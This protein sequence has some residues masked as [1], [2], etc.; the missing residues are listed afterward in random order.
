[1]TE[2]NRTE[3]NE[4]PVQLRCTNC[5]STKRTNSSVHFMQY[6]IRRSP[7]KL[8]RVHRGLNEILADATGKRDIELTVYDDRPPL[9]RQ[10]GD[11][12]AVSAAASWCPIRYPWSR[13]G[14][15]FRFIFRYDILGDRATKYSNTRERRTELLH[16]A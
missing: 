16:A 11:A 4:M 7:K 2:I 13:D 8:L 5:M 1:M 3:L 12:N 6:R 10:R 14:S 9:P 15:I